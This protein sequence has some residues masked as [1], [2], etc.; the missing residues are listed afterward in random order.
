VVEVTVNHPQKELLPDK[1]LNPNLDYV[2]VPFTS[3][4]G[5]QWAK[6][7]RVGWVSSPLLLS[8]TDT[9]AHRA[10]WKQK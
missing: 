4:M 5:P 2:E 1:M 8:V 9:E 6:V 3:F 10:L 7:R